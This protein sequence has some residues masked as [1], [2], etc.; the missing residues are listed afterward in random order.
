M[1]YYL[2]HQ[3]DQLGPFLNRG[4]L[5]PEMPW[6]SRPPQRC[7]IAAGTG[8]G[9]CMMLGEGPRAQ[10]LASEGGHASFAPSD[11][12]E[13]ALLKFAWRGNKHV[14]Q[15]RLIS[16]RYGFEIIYNFLVEVEGLD[17]VDSLSDPQ[18]AKFDRPL[19][20]GYLLQV[21]AEGD[22]P[23]LR[24]YLISSRSYLPARLAT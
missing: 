8:L 9:Q 13:L 18:K 6:D 21:A 19:D 3:P 15:E 2:C 10:V 5:A 17:R 16:G 7:L 20:Y 23:Q 24:Q 1:L 14:S 22:I 12:R 11:D 4:S